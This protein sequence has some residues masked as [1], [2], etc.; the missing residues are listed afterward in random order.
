M[1]TRPSGE[2]PPRLQYSTIL[3]NSGSKNASC[4]KQMYCA[5]MNTM[6]A[7]I[8]VHVHQEHYA[9]IVY[10]MHDP[11][12]QLSLLSSGS[13]PVVTFTQVATC[14]QKYW[15]P[16]NC[17]QNWISHSLSLSLSLSLT[18]CVYSLISGRLMGAMA[19]IS[20]SLI[21]IS[22]HTQFLTF[23]VSQ[24]QF[25]PVWGWFKI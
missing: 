16:S 6:Y 21:G 3:K 20:L 5:W 14:L 19:C 13:Y 18:D 12:T 23:S 9:C 2:L 22:P 17:R 4:I 24:F 25:L 15:L 8:N 1:S 11:V 10:E 7:H